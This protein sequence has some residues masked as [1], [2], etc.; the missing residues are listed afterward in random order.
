MYDAGDAIYTSEGEA[1]IPLDAPDIAPGDLRLWFDLDPDTGVVHY[2]CD[3]ALPSYRETMSLSSIVRVSDGSVKVH[4]YEDMSASDA[5]EYAIETVLPTFDQSIDRDIMD[6]YEKD[7]TLCEMENFSGTFVERLRAVAD[8]RGIGGD[9]W[10][11]DAPYVSELR[12]YALGH[13]WSVDA[14]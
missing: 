5:L 13:G 9:S 4:G 12:R 7:G 14:I 10:M 1:Y 8:D 3:L 2:E 11:T 6:A